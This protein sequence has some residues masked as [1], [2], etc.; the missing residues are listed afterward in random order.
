VR[1]R[2][3]CEAAI[4]N[5]RAFLDLGGPEAFADFIWRLCRRRAAAK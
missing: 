2:G 3:K 5:A 4:T 1:H